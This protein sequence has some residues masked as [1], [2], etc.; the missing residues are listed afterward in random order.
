MPRQVPRQR[1]SRIV[2]ERALKI[3]LVGLIPPP[4]LRVFSPQR[5]GLLQEILLRELAFLNS[6]NEKLLDVVRRA[7]KALMSVRLELIRQG[8]S[9]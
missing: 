3:A 2:S 1:S 4:L 7:Y 6:D 9:G 8:A 5:H